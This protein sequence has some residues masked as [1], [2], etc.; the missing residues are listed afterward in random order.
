MI[1]NNVRS[2]K[3]S[4][5]IQKNDFA[6]GKIIT[7]KNLENIF[8]F[9]RLCLYW[10]IL[11]DKDVDDNGLFKTEHYHLILVFNFKSCYK[12]YVLDYL[13]DLL[14]CS[15]N[16]ISVEPVINLN[17]SLRYLIH[18]D[19]EDKYQYDDNE[20]ITNNSVM[21]YRALLGNKITYNYLIECL[22]FVNFN[23]VRLIDVFITIDEYKRYRDVIDDII[24]D[25]LLQGK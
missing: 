11:H 4:V 20:I 18:L 3:W 2:N 10:Y 16:I 1:K 6:N 22:K 7:Y 19:D 15:S 24:Q 25:Y 5:I 21:L 8:R 9:N 12:K 23:K 17:I 14:N 13:C